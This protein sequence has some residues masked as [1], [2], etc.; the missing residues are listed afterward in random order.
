MRENLL[1]LCGRPKPSVYVCLW[2]ACDTP[3]LARAQACSGLEGENQMPE[4]HILSLVVRGV[5]LRGLLVVQLALV[6]SYIKRK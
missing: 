1:K 6:D 2:F 5:A 3:L 4:V